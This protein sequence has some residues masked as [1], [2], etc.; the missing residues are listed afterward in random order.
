MKCRYLEGE[1]IAPRSNAEARALVGKKVEY[2]QGRDIDR[3]G[4]GY[5]FP[6]IGVV[7]A[8]RGRDIA[9]D[10]SSNFCVHLN[11]LVEMRI[12]DGEIL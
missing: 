12:I 11:N 10:D 1:N 3:S 4:R 5:F 7:A 9:M 2:L 8:V 6:R